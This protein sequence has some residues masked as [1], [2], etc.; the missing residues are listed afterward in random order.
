[1]LWQSIVIFGGADFF[2]TRT[3]NPNWPEIKQ[4]LLPGQSSS[5]RPDLVNRVFR[6]KVQELMDDILKRNVLGRAVAFV[7][8]TEFQKRGLPHVHW[9]VFL[10]P[11]SKLHTPEGIDTLLSA[12]FPD[13]DEDPELFELVKQFMVHTPCDTP[14]SDA[15]CLHNAKCSK[16]F[17]K[18][19]RDQTTI[20]ED[21]YANLRRRDTGKKYHVRGHD[22]DNRWVVLFPPYWL[23]KFR[24]HINMECLFSVRCFKYICKHVYKGHDC[25]TMEFGT[26]ENEVKLYL[27]SRYISACEAIW[28]LYHFQMHDEFP[29]VIR[30]Q[31]HLPQQQMITWNAETVANLQYVVDD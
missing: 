25:T 16:N 9:I 14:N 8:T 6:L 2:I 17:P 7:W 30:L 18:P 29:N 13:L 31:I 26:C 1:M 5:D 3:A 20:N 22:V 24:C 15:S 4:A 28:R 21:S 11:D 19:F 27:D 12:Q 10:H 23:W